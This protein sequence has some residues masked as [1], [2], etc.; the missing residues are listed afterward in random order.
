ML[1]G[2]APA[3]TSGNKIGISEVALSGLGGLQSESPGQMYESQERSLCNGANHWLLWGVQQQ[4]FLTQPHM[5]CHAT[6]CT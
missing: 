6:L 4:A 5:P 2:V 3:P 1:P